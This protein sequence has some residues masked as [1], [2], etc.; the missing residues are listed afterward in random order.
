MTTL[1]LRSLADVVSTV[2]ADPRLWREHV[3]FDAGS[4]YWHR[5]ASLPEADLWLL[6]WLP[7]Q[8]TDLHDHGEATAAFTVVSGSLEEVRL[9]AGQRVS[10]SLTRGQVSWVPAGAVHDV[11]NRGSSPAISIHAYSPRLTEMTFWDLADGELRRLSS[12]ITDQPE[13]G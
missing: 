7:D 8:Q 11:G 4:R 2:A 5:L 9:R 13:V 12:V 3:R 1:A 10:R 6:T